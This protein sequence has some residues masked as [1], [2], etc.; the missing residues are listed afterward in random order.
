V[1]NLV[2]GD[3]VNTRMSNC[4]KNGKYIFAWAMLTCLAV[5]LWSHS[6]VNIQ[7]T[8]TKG[9]GTCM[10]RSNIT[11]ERVG[12]VQRCTLVHTISLTDATEKKDGGVI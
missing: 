10:V 1:T 8:S 2:V 4:K 12:S 6:V 9:D 7:N 3:H 5:R 11:E